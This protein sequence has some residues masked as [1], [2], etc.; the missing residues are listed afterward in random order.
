MPRLNI[1]S[2]ILAFGDADTVTSNPRLRYVDWTTDYTQ[3]PISSPENKEYT[4]APGETRTIFSGVR[5]LGID[6]STVFALTLNPTADGVYRLTSTGGTPPA[7]RTSRA[8]AISGETVTVVVNNNATITIAL[9][10]ASVPTFAAASVGDIVFVPNTTTGDS[11]SP[12]NILNVGFW[13]ILAIGPSGIGANRKLTLKRLAGEAFQGASEL[14]TISSNSQFV[15]FSSGAVRAG[16]NIVIGA[17]FSTV[18]QG[19]YIVQTVTDKWVEFT[20]GESLPLESAIQPTAAGINIYTAAKAFLRV[21]ADQPVYIHLNGGTE[22]TLSL[23][24]RT[25]ADPFGRGYLEMWGTVWQLEVVNRSSS[26]S[27]VVE[28]I[29][30]SE[31]E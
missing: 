10:A 22:N 23:K 12:F 25:P 30:A 2:N 16:D 20:S 24:P 6:N 21:E 28:I 11:A 27:A 18:T 31:A 1:H 9:A 4:L 7:F 29:S 15:V 26:S 17:G 13:V 14:V 5:A 8:V 3:I 19:I